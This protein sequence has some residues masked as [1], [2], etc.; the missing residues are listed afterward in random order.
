MGVAENIKN[1]PG[2]VGEPTKRIAQ[3]VLHVIVRIITGFFLGL[4]LSLIA[5]EI[6]SF[7]L[8]MLLFFT[9]LFGAIIF[10]LLG[11]LNLLQIVVFDLVCVLVLTLLKMYILLAPN[12]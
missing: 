7:G 1:I 12:I 9:T 5:Q 8:F 11:R 10:K 6:F 2:Q 4:V 3:G